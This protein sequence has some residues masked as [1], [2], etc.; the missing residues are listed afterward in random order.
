MGKLC[1]ELYLDNVRK[2]YKQAH[3]KEKSR[4]LEEFCD[5]SGYHKKHAIPIANEVANL[6]QI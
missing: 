4:I 3:R 6:V 5:A 1:M 2:R